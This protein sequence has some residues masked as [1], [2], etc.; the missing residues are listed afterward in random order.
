[1]NE[2]HPPRF[3]E[4]LLDSF[5]ADAAFRDAILGDLAQEHALRSE[6]YGDTAARLW[7]YRQAALTAPHLLRNWLAGARLADA[8]RLLN[9]AGLAYVLSMMITMGAFFGASAIGSEIDPALTRTVMAASTGILTFAGPIL[10]GYLAATF[11]EKKPMI[12][13]LALA[14]CW[15][16][17]QIFTATWMYLS[18][19][20]NLDA[21]AWMRLA[22]VPFL[23]GLFVIGGAIRVKR[24]GLA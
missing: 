1:M 20:F 22:I 14:C 7:Y 2:T 5:G 9:V 13:S 4:A 3:A 12:A 11:E 21:P 17:L 23:M 8:R 19:D 24:V 10:A 18:R 15:G 6:R 16:F